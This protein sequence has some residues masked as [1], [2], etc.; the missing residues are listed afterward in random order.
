MVE[1]GEGGPRFIGEEPTGKTAGGTEEGGDQPCAE[2]REGVGGGDVVL[3]ATSGKDQPIETRRDATVLVTES[4][5][6]SRAV[7]RCPH[8]RR[9]GRPPLGTSL[10]SPVVV[11]AKW[12][13]R[14]LR[15]FFRSSESEERSNYS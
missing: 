7:L 8:P 6:D 14:R 10:L 9:W 3:C 11:F 1:G 12:T 5:E 2:L 4:G 13:V 15:V